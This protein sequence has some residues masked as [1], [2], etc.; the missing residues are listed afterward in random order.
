MKNIL[1]VNS[2][3]KNCGVYDFGNRLFEKLKSS[4][5]FNLILCE[6]DSFTELKSFIENDIS[7]II[8]NYHPTTQSFLLKSL[9][10]FKRSKIFD[11]KIP[12]IG[13]I[14]EITQNIASHS[15]AKRKYFWRN[16]STINSMFDYY[17]VFD[18]TLIN[19]NRLVFNL[20]RP[21]HETE[22]L[23]ENSFKEN[24]DKPIISSFG[25]N[26]YNK[27]FKGLIKRVEKEFDN[28]EIR[29]NIPKNSYSTKENNLAELSKVSSKPG[30]NVIITNDYKDPT[31]TIQFLAESDLIFFN[32][33][34]EENRGISSVTDYAISAMKPIAYSNSE[35]FRNITNKFPDLSIEKSTLK[36]IMAHGNSKLDFFRKEWHKDNLL[37]DFENSISSIFEKRPQK[38]SNSIIMMSYILFKKFHFFERIYL[39]VLRDIFKIDIITQNLNQW[40]VHKNKKYE[41]TMSVL[42][43]SVKIS[44]EIELFFNSTL[45]ED[46]LEHFSSSINLQKKLVPNAFKRKNYKAMMNQGFIFESVSYL[47]SKFKNPRILSIGSYFDTAC[48]S[49][50]KTGY[51]IQE[52]DPVINYDLNTFISRPVKPTEKF[53]IIFSTSVIEHVKDDEKFLNQVDSLLTNGG[54][55]IMTCDFKSDWQDGM[56]KPKVNHRLYNRKDME[57]RLIS[58]MP[59]CEFINPPN[60]SMSNNYFLFENIKYQFATFVVKKTK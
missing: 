54:Y 8:Y 46:S 25:F 5:S 23:Y 57:Y 32:Y 50:I 13:I 24:S 58:K 22:I 15:L 42:N 37:Y 17:F 7:L 36:N 10:L 11:I 28:A 41:D 3:K 16:E 49:L 19:S 38:P 43:E 52:I 21:I 39:K 6:V 29:L 26:S 59:N 40:I 33:I 12:Q 14:H 2:K 35:M 51:Q 34:N 18:E 1:F 60:F 30:I 9:F 27:N 44:N 31:K 53:D 56:K 20:P 47:A 45:M 48:M 55:Y 4:K